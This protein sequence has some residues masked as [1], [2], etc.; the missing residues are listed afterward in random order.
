[1]AVV[2]C[3]YK[4]AEAE[5]R[6]AIATDLFKTVFTSDLWKKTITEN[7]TETFTGKDWNGREKKE[8]ELKTTTITTEES[9][10]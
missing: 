3:N 5:K 9:K 10:K 6:V 8:G 2:E 4:V 1:M 7:R